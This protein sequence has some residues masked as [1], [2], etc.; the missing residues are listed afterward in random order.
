MARVAEGGG[1]DAAHGFAGAV[2]QALSQGH[3]GFGQF[4][5]VH[6]FVGQAQF[7]GPGRI[8][9]FGGEHEMSGHTGACGEVEQDAATPIRME[10]DFHE[11][12][13]ELGVAGC[14]AKVGPKCQ[15]HARASARAL[16]QGHHGLGK[17]LQPMGHLGAQFQQGFQLAHA[18]AFQGGEDP[19]Q[20]ASSA[21]AT[22]LA[23]QDERLGVWFGGLAEGFAE[24]LGHFR[25]E[26][27]EAIRAVERQGDDAI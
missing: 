19:S 22:A 20:V 5:R 23:A 24:A 1:L 16:D 18:P 11:G 8:H 6:H 17:G 27:V 14:E 7:L 2:G 9:R 3:A 12:H 21:E 26:G 10:T 13:G 15:T 25:D 4:F